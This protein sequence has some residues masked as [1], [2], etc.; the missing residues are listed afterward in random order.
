MA[1]LW[2]LAESSGPGGAGA[3]G[4]AVAEALDLGLAALPWLSGARALVVVLA[5]RLG[6]PEPGGWRLWCG[7]GAQGQ[8]VAEDRLAGGAFLGQAVGFRWAQ[9]WLCCPGWLELGCSWSDWSAGSGSELAPLLLSSRWPL[10]A[11]VAGCAGRCRVCPV[12]QRWWLGGSAARRAVALVLLATSAWRY[13]CPESRRSSVGRNRRWR[14]RAWPPVVLWAFGALAA[15]SGRPRP[16][17]AA[18]ACDESGAG[19]VLKRPSVSSGA[20]GASVPP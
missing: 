16:S 20:E 17:T 10:P 2:E 11:P 15:P 14:L 13:G 4:P 1:G 7:T 9:V 19:P 3:P 8:A 6:G 18:L 12:Q 5:C